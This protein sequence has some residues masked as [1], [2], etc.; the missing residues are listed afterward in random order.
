[1]N[2]ASALGLVSAS[3][4]SVQDLNISFVHFP[5]GMQQCQICNETQQEARGSDSE[6]EEVERNARLVTSHSLELKDARRYP[7]M[8]IRCR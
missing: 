8:Y 6:R 1:M 3:L 7:T 2:P 5:P 4:Q